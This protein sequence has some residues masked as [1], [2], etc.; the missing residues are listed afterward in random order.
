MANYFIIGGDGKEYGPVTEADV[1]QWIAE[2][3]LNEQSLA[4]A[5]SD[6]EFR[7]LAAFPEFAGAFSPGAP[8]R[9]APLRGNTRGPFVA[10]DYELDIGSCISSGFRLLKDKFNVVFVG[11]LVY[12]L[13]EGVLGG[14]ANIP[15]IGPIISIANFVISGPLLGGVFYLLIRAIRD[16]PVEIVAV[17]EGFRRQFGQ[18]FLATL[19]Q[20]LLIG[21]CLIPFF[22]VAAIKMIPMMHQLQ[23]GSHLSPEEMTAA[24]K[25]ILIA[26][27]PVL[28]ICLIPVIYLATC[29]KF[30]LPL[31]I[32]RNL[33]FWPAMK[34]SF[35][36]VNKHWWQ[37]F[38]LIIL[39]SLIN[40]AGVLACCIGVL[41][42]VPIGFGALMYAYETIFSDQA[43]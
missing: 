38:G 3:R 36:M 18:L 10:H 2:G 17:F 42:T 27:L 40:V 11:V 16:E 31:I 43:A 25:P 33:D 7:P 37:V 39:I 26:S 5:E 32:D 19:V 30:S 13:I 9:I 34:T 15:I 6:A 20:A 41:F 12:L 8:E 1:R 4:K 28:L 14:F 29:W 24:F 21:A 22:V 23:P 35:R